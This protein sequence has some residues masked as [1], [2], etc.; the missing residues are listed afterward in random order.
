MLSN[1]FGFFGVCSLKY[2][3]FGFFGV[4]SLIY[5]FSLIYSFFGFFGDFSLFKP[6]L[7]FLGI[8][9]CLIYRRKVLEFAV[10]RLMKK[11]TGCQDLI[12]QVRKTS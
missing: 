12:F 9:P 7:I 6:I 2:P 5:P 11:S 4:F 3:F 8:F 1:S 10:L